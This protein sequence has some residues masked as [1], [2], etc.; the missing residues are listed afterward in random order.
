MPRAQDRLFGADALP[1]N[2]TVMEFWAWALGDLCDDDVKGWFAE[3]LVAKLLGIPTPRRV[4]WANSDLI[5]PQGVRIEVKSSSYWQS[6]KLIDEFG[7][8]LPEPTHKLPQDR[9]IAWLAR[10]KAPISRPIRAA[11]TMPKFDSTE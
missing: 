3:W 10:L 4:S 2:G 1:E 5:T 8:P 9:T 7:H 11:G 6:W